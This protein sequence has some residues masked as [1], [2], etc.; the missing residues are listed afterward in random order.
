MWKSF[1]VSRNLL[2]S[3]SGRPVKVCHSVVMAKGEERGFHCVVRGGF[4]I[5]QLNGMKDGEEKNLRS[6]NAW[7]F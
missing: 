7:R 1:V 2:L 3:V 4:H 6:L 5:L